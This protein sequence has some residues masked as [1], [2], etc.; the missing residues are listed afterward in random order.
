MSRTQGHPRILTAYSDDQ[1][2]DA[3]TS[4]TGET[5]VSGRG[6]SS[7]GEWTTP[8]TVLVGDTLGIRI[9]ALRKAYL[10]GKT[11]S[12]VSARFYAKV[13]V[14]KLMQVGDPADDMPVVEVRDKYV[15]CDGDGFI[16][17]F[18]EPA[19]EVEAALQASDDEWGRYHQY[20]LVI[21]SLPS[22]PT[23]TA[24]QMRSG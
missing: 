18:S 11:A 20:K 12:G 15:V 19:F 10:W 22:L 3:A 21:A 14:L 13:R 2:L 17:D 23:L 7:C 16:P 24:R 5:R 8:S 1:Y 9:V 4:K 6:R